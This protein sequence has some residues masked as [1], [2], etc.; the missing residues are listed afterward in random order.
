MNQSLILRAG[1][2]RLDI[3]PGLGGSIAGLHWTDGDGERPILRQSPEALDQVL[4]AAC[5]PLVPFV[6]RIRGGAFTFRGREIRLPLNMAG[7]PSPI[8]GQGWQSA[9]RVDSCDEQGAALSFRHEAGDWP[10]TYD[11]AEQFALD[12]GGLSVRLTC[13]NASDQPMPCGLGQHPYF[14]C[15]P[16]TRIDSD[17][18]VAWTIDEKVLPV[19]QVPAT[20][21]YDLK[22]RL[23][24]GQDLDNGWG[25]W[26][27]RA[28]LSDPGWPY[29]VAVSSPQARFF[30][31]YSPPTGGVCVAEPVTHANAALNAPETDWS[32]LGMR[33]LEPGAEMSLD[34]RLDVM[35]R[36]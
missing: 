20:G 14:P 23:V 16:E 17:V 5:F 4:E 12:E 33:V 34:M 21:R 24:C 15:G 19:A 10:W 11:A 31:L 36:S 7:E 6:N 18:T 3:R 30:Q 27:G 25:G 8:H 35:P 2:L 28:V 13:R 29:E 32:E 1:K 26:G 22:D 9:W